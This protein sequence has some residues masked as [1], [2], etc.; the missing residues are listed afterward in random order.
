M[1][2]SRV[3]NALKDFPDRCNQGRH[4]RLSLYTGI[5]A[6]NISGMTIHAAL[7]L[8]QRS[9]GDLREHP[10]CDLVA[11]WEGVDD[12]FAHEASMMTASCS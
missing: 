6:C 5:A 10:L 4:F 2:R 1:R 11:M 12:L 8:N 9:R 3:I 7:S